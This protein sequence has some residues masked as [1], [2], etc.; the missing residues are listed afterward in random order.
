MI[1]SGVAE[2]PHWMQL[3]FGGSGIPP[4]P[5]KMIDATMTLPADSLVS[6]LSTGACQTMMVTM[7][8]L[9]GH[10]VRVGLE[11]NIYYSAGQL[12]ESNAQMVERVVRIAKEIGREVATPEEARAM[13]GLGAPRQY[14]L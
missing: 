5:E 2:A 7:A 9:L 8:I 4:A 13:M 11:D 10:H 12:A 6:I 14:P 3:A 1:A